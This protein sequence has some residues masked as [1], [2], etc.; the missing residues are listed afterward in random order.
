MV[1]F[2]RRMGAATQGPADAERPRVAHAVRLRPEVM[3][4]CFFVWLYRRKAGNFA[5]ADES[6]CCAA[7]MPPLCKGRWVRRTRRD[8]W[9]DAVGHKKN[10]L[11]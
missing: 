5:E 4:A 9:G 1:C 6:G 8:C 2:S 7:P 10:S 3:K 11:L